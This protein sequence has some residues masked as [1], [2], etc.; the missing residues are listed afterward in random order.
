MYENEQR[1]D[2][3][4]MYS[5]TPPRIEVSTKIDPPAVSGARLPRLWRRPIFFQWRSLV[6][7][8]F[9]ERHGLDLKVQVLRPAMD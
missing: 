9:P 5:H 7:L 8:P 2:D 4:V 6:K 3:S 1:I